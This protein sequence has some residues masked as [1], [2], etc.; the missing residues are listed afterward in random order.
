MEGAEDVVWRERG[1]VFSVLTKL[2]SSCQLV[3]P[4]D[5]IKRRSAA[6][7]AACATFKTNSHFRLRH[8]SLFC[9]VSLIC[10][11]ARQPVGDDVGF[12]SVGPEGG[13]GSGPSFLPQSGSASQAAAGLPVCGGHRQPLAVERKGIA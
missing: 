5:D 13:S 9:H 4:P 7:P 1:Q 10:R 6:I 3:R 12:L 8:F 11:S 2:G